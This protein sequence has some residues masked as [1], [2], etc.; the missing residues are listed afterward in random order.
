MSRKFTK[1][2]QAEAKAFLRKMLKPGAEVKVVQRHVS[3][4]GMSRRLSLFYV[5]GRGRMFDIT[6][7]AAAAMGDRLEDDWTIKV[8]GAGM[9]M[10]FHLV[11]GLSRTL[12][13]NGHR[14]TG[15]RNCPSN[16]HT[17]DYGT[18]QRAYYD[19]HPEDRE[20]SYHDGVNGKAAHERMRVYVDEQL[21]GPTGTLGY[22]KG[23]QHSDGG[24]ALTK[25]TL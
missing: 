13:P 19:E 12:Y 24:Y 2:E 14:C 5:D 16:D 9:D 11:Y 25:R 15:K 3:S 17:N 22:R 1:E 7:K 21:E 23:R 20:V 6:S 4:S 10:H 18:A 8:G